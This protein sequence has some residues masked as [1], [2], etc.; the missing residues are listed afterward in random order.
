[1]Q[2]AVVDI[3]GSFFLFFILHRQM[4]TVKHDEWAHSIALQQGNLAE[5][6][7]DVPAYKAGDGDD[8]VLQVLES[9]HAMVTNQYQK[10]VCGLSTHEFGAARDCNLVQPA[11]PV[12]CDRLSCICLDMNLLGDVFELGKEVFNPH[13]LQ[14]GRRMLVNKMMLHNG[15]HYRS[16]EWI[17]CVYV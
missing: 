16:H 11:V 10:P 17:T 12:D 14:W 13:L 1:M 8:G 7:M 2:P 5:K 6:E 9:S 3:P 15:G 4:S